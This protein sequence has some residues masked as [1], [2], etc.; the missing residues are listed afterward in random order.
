MHIKGFLKRI[1]SFFAALAVGIFLASFF[2]S[3]ALPNFSFRRDGWRRHQEYHRMMEMENQRL[4][5][6]NARLRRETARNQTRQDADFGEDITDLVPPPP[7]L[8]PFAPRT[9]K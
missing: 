7:P 5:E 4:R 8:P 6:E 1:V 2:V 3:V 9:L